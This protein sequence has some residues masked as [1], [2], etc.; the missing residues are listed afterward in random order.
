MPRALMPFSR[1]GAIAFRRRHDAAVC[2]RHFSLMPLSFTL[3][4]LFIFFRLLLRFRH[5]AS[6]RCA[7]DA[8]DAADYAFHA[9]FAMRPLFITSSFFIISFHYCFLSF[10]FT[11]LLFFFLFRFH[12]HISVF[13]ADAMPLPF[14]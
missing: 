1:F 9:A 13:A 14:H 10:F 7:F 2:R 5:A 12:F 3:M 11:I 4:P 6:L 8:A